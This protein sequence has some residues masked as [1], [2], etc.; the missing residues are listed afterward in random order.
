[1]LDLLRD[2]DLVVRVA[3]LA[4]PD[5]GS[6]HLPTSIYGLM[7]R[8]DLLQRY[9]RWQLAKRRSGTHDVKNRSEVDRTGKKL[10]KQKGTGNAR[11][12]SAA[13][14]QFR[15]GGRAFG[16][17]PRD[18]V[19]HLPKKVRR[20]A[21]RH[22]LSAKVKEHEIIVLYDAVPPLHKTKPFRENLDRLNLTSALIV[23]G[24]QPD[25]NLLLAARSVANVDVLPVG[26]LNV[27]DI[28]KH[29]TLVLTLDAVRTLDERFASSSR[30]EWFKDTESPRPTGSVQVGATA[31]EDRPARSVH[32]QSAS[33]TALRKPEPRK[34]FFRETGVTRLFRDLCGADASLRRA[35][36]RELTTV[37]GDDAFL[38]GE[39]VG[40]L[41][42]LL[43]SD[44]PDEAFEAALSLCRLSFPENYPAAARLSAGGVLP[45]ETEER[46]REDLRHLLRDQR[47]E[48][49][50]YVQVKPME[51]A[52]PELSLLVR[53]GA[54]LPFEIGGR[55]VQIDLPDW[56][57]R[58]EVFDVTLS[59]E[60]VDPGSVKL[61]R[62]E[63]GRGDVATVEIQC[64]V[65]RERQA[66]LFLDFFVDRRWLHRREIKLDT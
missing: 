40:R 53:L 36:M 58:V 60:A 2:G 13:A 15:G 3:T 48:Y 5:A 57:R 18:H 29:R 33:G 22:A 1:M 54:N 62:I 56:L 44:R 4:G 7:P 34:D 50:A 43:V 10:A 52:S 64:Q 30:F 63:P 61:R 65:G 12:G 11:H 20:L 38:R 51:R 16:P 26:G 37:A 23:T 14:P 31:V 17:Q 47:V 35:A 42:P 32:A 25:R 59:G 41:L 21:L 46:L 28:L 9:V 55:P 39:S 66:P 6:A 45:H 27:Y 24:P 49:I 19:H 8:A